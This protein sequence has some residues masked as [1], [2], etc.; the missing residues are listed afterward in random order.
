MKLIIAPIILFSTIYT[1]AQNILT[2]KSNVVE[3]KWLVNTNYQMLWYAVKDTVRFEIGKTNTSINI[4]KGKIIVATS[5]SMK[6]AKTPWI[7]STIA[8]AKDL[9][10]VYHS[11]YNAQRNMVLKFGAIVKG[12]Y[13][14][15]T[16]NSNTVINDTTTQGY[17]DSNL[18]PTLITWLPLHEG[19]KQDISIYDHKPGSKTGVIRATVQ[20]VKKGTFKTKRYGIRNVWIVAVSDEIGG[21]ENGISTYF[22]DVA[23]RRL[24][25]QQIKAGSRTMEMELVEL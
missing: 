9:S 18:Y 16:N 20:D 5:I 11:S 2:P 17:F 1:N 24:W 19:Y 7:D 8:N 4:S 6:Q 13:N 15:K 3:K 22:I 23:D 10:P 14:D 12:F 21:T 25:K